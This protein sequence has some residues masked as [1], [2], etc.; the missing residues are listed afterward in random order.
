MW[1]SRITRVTLSSRQ[2][3]PASRFGCVL[4][5]ATAFGIHCPEVELRAGDSS[6][7]TRSEFG[8]SSGRKQAERRGTGHRGKRNKYRGKGNVPGWMRHWLALIATTPM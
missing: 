8:N 1:G 7:G 5:H 2:T 4:R 3:I 6:L